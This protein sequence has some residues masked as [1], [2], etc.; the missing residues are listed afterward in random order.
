MPPGY[1]DTIH[2]GEVIDGFCHT[3]AHPLESMPPFRVRNYTQLA[4]GNR[5]IIADWCSAEGVLDW[6]DGF[7]TRIR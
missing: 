3:E 6:Q 7:I 5:E 2:E 4:A 1:A